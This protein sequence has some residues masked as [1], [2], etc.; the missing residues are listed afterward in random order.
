MI[1]LWPRQDTEYKGGSEIGSYCRLQA[2][3]L[4]VPGGEGTRRYCFAPS[5][6]QKL[7]SYPTLA[8]ARTPSLPKHT[9]TESA[10]KGP[11]LT[12][13]HCKQT[14]SLYEK[15]NANHRELLPGLKLSYQRGAH[16][17]PKPTLSHTRK[18][19]NQRPN[20]VDL[21]SWRPFYP[22]REGSEFLTFGDTQLRRLE[23]SS[24]GEKARKTWLTK[25]Q[26]SHFSQMINQLSQHHLFQM[27]LCQKPYYL[28]QN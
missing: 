22:Q 1:F 2:E 26:N 24:S 15:K 21:L 23:P 27:K 12:L 7:F 11:I 18:H 9:H 14:S 4:L 16:Q 17:T 28:K 19:G 6:P 8:R 25:G 13:P 10:N 5:C 20:P 3:L